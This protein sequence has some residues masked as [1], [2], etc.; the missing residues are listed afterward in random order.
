MATSGDY[1]N[2]FEVDGIRYSHTLDPRTGRPVAHN[3]ASVTVIAESTAQADGYA[4]AINVLGAEEGLKLAERQN[5]AVLVIIR[6]EEG[7]TAL[8]STALE[9]YLKVDEKKPRK[10]IA[11]KAQKGDLL[12]E[13]TKIY[14]RK[15]KP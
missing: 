2:F 14:R 11:Q 7:F 15:E 5:L 4:T 3:V 1:R 9:A 13:E 6:Q 10:K 12:N 8:T